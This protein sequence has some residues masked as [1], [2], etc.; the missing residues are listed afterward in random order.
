LDTLPSRLAVF[1][2]RTRYAAEVAEI[3]LRLHYAG[4]VVYVDNLPDGPAP[5][6]VGPVI[7]SSAFDPARDGQGVVVATFPPGIR[8]LLATQLRAAGA[9]Q[10]PVLVD[11]T[12]V[13]ASSASLAEGT[14][15]NALAVVAASTTIGAFVTVNRSV[16][17][18]HDCAVA[19]FVSFGPGC[20]LTGHVTVERGAFV[21]AGA[22]T[23]PGV[24]I[25]ASSIVGAGAVVTTSV[26]PNTVVVGN[27]AK[28]IKDTD[29]HG[30]GVPGP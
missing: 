10:Y 16:S 27:P 30:G 7:Q 19:D 25:G 4:D 21:G 3:L 20:V 8:H 5:P 14:T 12:A 13:V 23:V 28:A 1:P 18:G 24:T 15:V 26:A 29:G 6:D 2:L 22:V 11:P 9:T 17:I